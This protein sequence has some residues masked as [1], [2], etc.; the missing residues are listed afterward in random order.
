[1]VINRKSIA[2][3]ARSSL[4]TGVLSEYDRGRNG[5]SHLTGSLTN[6]LSGRHQV[7]ACAARLAHPDRFV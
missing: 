1:M 5:L 4:E 3:K 7:V 2:I 6:S